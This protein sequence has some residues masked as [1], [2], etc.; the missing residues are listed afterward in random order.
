MAVSA[1][2]LEFAKETFAPFGAIAARR[3]FGGAGLYCDDLFFAIIVEDA[4]YLKA[5][6]ATRGDFE[7]AAC[8][9]FT[10]ET[11]SGVNASISYY[12]AP[13]SIFDDADSL[14]YWTTLALDAASRAA[15]L[16]K[17]P[18]KK[19]ARKKAQR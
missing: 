1:A 18:A 11:K 10:Y 5:D 17:A 12:S 15:R 2:F 6:D 14:R 7:G 19:R 13:D 4:L 3:M 8:E 16:K 9:P